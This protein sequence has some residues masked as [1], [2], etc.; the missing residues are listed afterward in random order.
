MRVEEELVE[1]MTLS[2]LPGGTGESYG[3][4]GV[5]CPDDKSSAS[6]SGSASSCPPRCSSSV[7]SRA[8]R[9]VSER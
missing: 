7:L 4:Y 1:L 2:V 8:L 6:P 9:C 3:E 5:C